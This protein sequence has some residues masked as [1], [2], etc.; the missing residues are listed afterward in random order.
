MSEGGWC[1]E[2][3]LFAKVMGVEWEMG[4]NERD[5]A[6]TAVFEGSGANE[7]LSTVSERQKVQNKDGVGGGATLCSASLSLSFSRVAS[8]FLP[9]RD[10]VQPETG[11]R[12]LTGY[13]D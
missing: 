7:G 3:K 2:R 13:R 12:S 5:E 6:K 8:A 10:H 11:P 9:L 4:V 1:R